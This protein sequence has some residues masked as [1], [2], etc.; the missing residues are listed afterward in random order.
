MRA[1]PVEVQPDHLRRLVTGDPVA[2]V[3]ELVWNSLDAEADLVRITLVRGQLGNVSQVIVA[4]DG[5]GMSYERAEQDF[6][7]LGGSWKRRG[8]R[9][10]NQTRDLH[11]S[12]GKGRWRAFAVGAH[13]TWDS[14]AEGTV[15]RGHA[16][17]ILTGD[18]GKIDRFQ[19]SD[20]EP[21]DDDTG[22]T[23]TIT[24]MGREPDRL[25]SEAARMDLTARFALYLQRYRGVQIIFDGE[26]L[27][28]AD[29][30][31]ERAEIPLDLELDNGPA[32]LLVIEWKVPDVDRAL[33]LCDSAGI[34][35]E[36]A[37]VQ[38]HAPGFSFTAYLCW[39]GF[40]QHENV[41]L[42]ADLADETVSPVV[43]AARDA[44]RRHFKAKI[45]DQTRSIVERWKAEKVY[46]YAGEPRGHIARLER[47]LFDV[48]AVAAAPAVDV[49]GASP[50]SKKL[51]LT[52]LRQAVATNPNAL[53]RIFQEVLELP[54]AR[55]HEL[56]ELL[57]RTP[58]TSMISAGN[59]IADRLDFL[60][61]LNLL[62]F[63][64]DNK[65]RLKERTQLHRILAQETWVFGEEYA[66][67]VD[68]QGLTAVLRR[69]I[70]DMNRTALAPEPVR[71]ADGKTRIVDLML[72]RRVP[73]GRDRHEY[74]V[75]E[76]KAPDVKVGQDELNQIKKYAL[77]VARDERFN[78]VDASWEFVLVANELQEIAEFEGGQKDRPSGLIVD[79]PGIRVWVR[80]WGEVLSEAEHRLKFVQRGLE[81]APTNNTAMAYLAKVHSKYLPEETL[82]AAADQPA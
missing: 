40:R 70:K 53:R 23:V 38:I 81:Y 14:V 31:E 57:E 51:S 44:L 3:A 6:S 60:H 52:L 29:V 7:H 69:H 58:L 78:K 1:L 8:H 61:A 21:T 34:A 76:L 32:H 47:D 12:E 24:P 56:E 82:L 39:D 9:S 54:P 72:S 2:G 33:Y 77:A 65:A 64:P 48:V 16:R 22:T 63:E 28:P 10:V 50:Q 43:E 71:D 5:H 55:L 30:Q 67:G 41:L 27:S 4:D 73:Q 37:T 11:G 75:V 15:G 20:P 66:L 13:I 62:L 42:V 74:L 59:M 25:L 19:I 35:L 46:P 68:D 80:L 79:V 49:D 18:L 26:P 36:R 17:T 45:G